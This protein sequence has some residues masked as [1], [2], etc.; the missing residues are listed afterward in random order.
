MRAATRRSWTPTLR[1]DVVV[2]G[3]VPRARVEVRPFAGGSTS[4]IIARREHGVVAR[5]KT[6]PHDGDV[7]AYIEAVP[8]RRRRVDAEALRVLMEQ[9]TGETATMWG[10]SIVGFGTMPYTNTSGTNDWFVVG[11]SARKAAL[12][13][14]GVHDGYAEPDPLLDELG[15][16]STGKGCLYIKR[17]A[18]VD[19]QVLTQLITNAWNARPGA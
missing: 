11:F 18:D 14:Y 12:T 10:P 6:Q 17:L 15:L 4:W 9:A 2:L 3:Q 19:Q 16:R 8:D 7:G 13:I 1:A 5:I